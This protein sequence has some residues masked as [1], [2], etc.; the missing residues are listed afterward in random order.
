[1]DELLEEAR[2]HRQHQLE[3]IPEARRDLIAKILAKYVKN[4]QFLFNLLTTLFF[5]TIVPAQACIELTILALIYTLASPCPWCY[6][7]HHHHH[8]AY[9]IAY[10]FEDILLLSLLRD[11]IL[12]FAY[13]WG[14]GAARQRPYLKAAYCLA[15]ISIL[16][17]LWKVDIVSQS[18]LLPRN[19]WPGLVAA[20]IVHVV[21]AV[22]HVVT[23]RKMVAW[24]ERR[25]E[26][27]L[28]TSAGYEVLEGTGGR[29]GDYS[30]G[31]RLRRVFSYNQPPLVSPPSSL[32]LSERDVERSKDGSGSGSTVV[33]RDTSHLQASASPLTIDDN[34]LT[35]EELADDDSKWLSSCLCGSCGGGL[36]I[37]RVHY[38][39][40]SPSTPTNTDTKSPISSG[41]SGGEGV[42]LIHGFGGGVFSW[43]NIMQPLADACNMSVVAFDRPGFGLTSRPPSPHIHDNA[44]GDGGGGGGGHSPYTIQSHVALAL[45]VARRLGI[46]RAV[47]VGAG[48]GALVAL[49]A[50]AQI[51][52]NLDLQMNFPPGSLADI[53]SVPSH[54]PPPPP[55]HHHHYANDSSSTG[56]DVLQYKVGTFS[57]S[58]DAAWIGSLPVR[59][60]C[61]E[62][63]LRGD[64][65]VAI[66]PITTIMSGNIPA[67]TFDSSRRSRD[68]SGE[69][70]AAGN[71]GVNFALKKQGLLGTALQES[72]SIISSG[73]LTCTGLVLLHPEL[74]GKIGPNYIRVLQKSS[75]GRRV[76]QRL[77]RSD[78]PGEMI[79]I[80]RRN[81]DTAAFNSSSSSSSTTTT[82]HNNNRGGDVGS[83]AE[84]YRL[85]LYL[86]NWDDALMAISSSK[87][88]IG[89][90]ERAQLLKT[91]NVGGLRTLVV[92]GDVDGK[93]PPLSCSKVAASCGG[94]LGVIGD[95]GH[96]SYEEQP[97]AVVDFLREFVL[98]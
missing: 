48:D 98:E 88:G 76:C 68:S 55:P 32:P 37:D 63:L 94:R 3:E 27:G 4:L 52:H 7:H 64:W 21:F 85:P 79:T 22:T 42:V 71:N 58:L 72:P 10:S 23:A 2:L 34:V 14:N 53:G 36:A 38:K 66:Q 49:M 91:V 90:L 29:R 8:I 6:Y 89:E 35:I 65:P 24:A 69:Y 84:L 83:V 86:P 67:A 12:I 20:C 39:I 46:Q 81:I 40:A 61:I 47:F 57:E 44:G 31:G 59:R 50:A 41:T 74:S 25:W 33:P 56:D 51:V 73:V 11:T 45:H 5:A 92:T 15:P 80:D 70:S 30:S 78:I 19:Y 17:A 93:T 96:H 54:T 60:A 82:S 75:I 28:P 87:N 26:V 62:S 77:L 43:R 16:L 95:C 1:M 13:I 97:G 9:N 18:H